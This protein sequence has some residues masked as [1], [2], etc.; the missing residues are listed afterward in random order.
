MATT[1]RLLQSDEFI[2]GMEESEGV[3]DDEYALYGIYGV[4]WGKSGQQVS[5][6]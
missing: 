6:V 4:K 5:D 2:S 1:G 3:D